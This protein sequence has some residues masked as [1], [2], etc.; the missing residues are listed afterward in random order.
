MHTE[1]GAQ[2]REPSKPASSTELHRLHLWQMQP[3]RDVLVIGAIAGTIYAGYAMRTVTVPLLI[4]LALA[5]LF[6][7]VVARISR[8]RFMTR[9]LAVTVIL[10]AL[11]VVVAAVVGIVAPLAVGQALSFADNLRSGSYDKPIERVV[12]LVPS[13]YREEVRSWKQRIIRSKPVQEV[14]PESA[15]IEG[16][17]APVAAVTQK[18]LF[19]SPVF[20]VVGSGSARVYSIAMTLL[21]LG[22]IAFLIPF[23]FYYFSV[24]W[25]NIVGFFASFVPDDRRDSVG[26]IVSEMDRA[27]AGFVR[28]RIVICTVMGVMFAVGWQLCGVPYGIAL[29]V[30]TGVLSIVPYLGGIGVPAAIGLLA[31][32]QFGLEESQ[33][34]SLLA[35]ALWPTAVFVIV[36][37]IEGYILTPIIAGKATNLDPVTIVVAILAGGS[38]A[39]V[40]GMLLAIPAAACGKIAAKRLLLPRIADWARGRA[41]DPLPLGEA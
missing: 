20:D 36:Q 8:W 25:P 11:G 24:Y 14:E 22:L 19:E 29:G 4:A 9:P 1:G 18:S 15:S 31:V 30:V 26:S 16:P 39:G 33:R 7:P 17:A 2:S 34:M 13:E 3:V 41:R 6:E 38:I 21:Q 32:D 23:Y 35:I 40:Y 5:Y 27:V 12:E 28:G 37:T 10:G